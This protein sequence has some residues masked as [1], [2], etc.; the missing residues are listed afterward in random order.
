MNFSVRQARAADAHEATAVLRASISA[1]C[2]ADHGND[3]KV[4]ACWLAN[5]T[6]G[7]VRTWIEGPGR[8]V[9]AEEHG[10]IVGVGAATAPGDITLNYVLPE[11]RFRGVS[12][13]VLGALEAH[14]RSRGFT[15]ITLSSTRTAHRFYR[16]MGY[17][18]AG[19]AQDQDGLTAYRMFKDLAIPHS[20]IPHADDRP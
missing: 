3:P 20:R 9:V 5:K 11:A 17:V 12:K 4:L 2:V 8:F 6:P 18:D 19:Q 13:A 16:A 7:D 14:L 1:L 15:H 10:R